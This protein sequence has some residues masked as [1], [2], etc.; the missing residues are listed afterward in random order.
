MAVIPGLSRP[1]ERLKRSVKQRLTRQ[2]YPSIRCVRLFEGTKRMT[3]KRSGKEQGNLL[4]FLHGN[5]ATDLPKDAL[6]SPAQR[7]IEHW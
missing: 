7:G 1:A 2:E 4:G 3:G 5:S 6:A